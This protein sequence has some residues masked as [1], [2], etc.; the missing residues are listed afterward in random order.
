[1]T[2]PIDLKNR[3]PAVAINYPR[4]RDG[5]H[6][7]GVRNSQGVVWILLNMLAVC[8]Y[9][10]AVLGEPSESY[11]EQLVQEALERL[12]QSRTTFVIAHRL[13]TITNANRIVVLDEGRVVEQGT[14]LELLNHKKMLTDLRINHP[15]AIHGV[16]QIKDSNETQKLWSGVDRMIDG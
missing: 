7:R 16:S 2:P 6:S 12:M 1:M 10:P 15:N 3:T 14:H 5:R 8:L 11:R 4:R 13:S 9:L